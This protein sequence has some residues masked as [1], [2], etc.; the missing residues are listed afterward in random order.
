MSTSPRRFGPVDRRA[1]PGG[2][3]ADE[4]VAGALAVCLDLRPVSEVTLGE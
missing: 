4:P 3:A 1:Q 2:R